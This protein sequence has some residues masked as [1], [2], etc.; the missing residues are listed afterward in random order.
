MNKKKFLEWKKTIINDAKK[1]KTPVSCQFELTP[2]CNL[3][4]KMCYVHNHD[5]NKLKFM[6]LSTEQWKS[7]FDDAFNEGMMFATLTGGECLLRNDF[8]ELYLHLWTKQI[9]IIVISNGILFTPE[10]IEFFKKYPPDRIQISLYGSSEE[11][12]LNVTGHR[13]FNKVANTIKMLHESGINYIVNVTAS[14]YIVDDYIN[15]V[16]FLKDN[17]YHFNFSEMYLITNRDNPEKNDHFLQDSDIERLYTER[18]LLYGELCPVNILPEIGGLHS[19]PHMCGADCSAGNSLCSITWD[20]YMHPCTNIMIGTGASVLDMGY[21]EAWKKTVE[22]GETVLQ[23][24]E[25]DGCA[26]L[27]A[28]PKCITYRAID[29]FAGHCNPNICKMTK[30]LV[31]AGVKKLDTPTQDD[32]DE[33]EH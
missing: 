30:R 9:F 18:A 26:Y 2:R 28:C 16:R 24:A 29:L 33:F 14:S 27:S 1:Y 32:E 8:K 7:I 23:P 6:E 19:E 13:C 25:C 22:I 20:G 11:G 5:S 17:S 31:A 21:S 10:L 15:T 3:D 12:Y 4:C